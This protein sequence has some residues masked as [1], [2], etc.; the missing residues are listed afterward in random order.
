MLDF[1]TRK[2]FFHTDAETQAKLKMKSLGH[3]LLKINIFYALSHVV[4]VAYTGWGKGGG[5]MDI[6]PTL[7][8][9]LSKL[10]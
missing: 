8:P 10:L 1:H 4:T 3:N 6:I 9:Y 7:P 5:V 2:A